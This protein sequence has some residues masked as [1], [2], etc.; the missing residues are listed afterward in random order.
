MIT[1]FPMFV[2]NSFKGG[3]W[4][5][6]PFM[7]ELYACTG[8][9]FGL[10]SICTMAAISYD[11]YNV[12][13]NGMN[14]T[15]MTY[16]KRKTLSISFPRF[17]NWADF[18]RQ[19]NCNYSVLLGLRNRLEHPSLCRM[20]KIHS[21]RN[22][23]FMLIRLLN[24]WYNGKKILHDKL[25]ERNQQYLLE[26]CNFKNPITDD[27]VH[28]LPLRVWLLHATYYHRFLLLSHCRSHHSSWKGVART[29]KK[30]ECNVASV[31][32]WP[33]CPECGNSCRQN[34]HDEYFFMG[35]YVDTICSN[36]FTRCCWKPR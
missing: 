7:C 16:G 26:Y 25:S 8:S 19:S 31:Q 21:R 34:R 5:F 4:L 33:K 13:V 1:Q 23:G 32:C 3:V 10:C 9:I 18:F 22:L 27:I 17:I 30:N 2:L 20:G 24:S 11:R 15:R 12:I 28:L 35:S 14:G 29:S 36:M 6:G